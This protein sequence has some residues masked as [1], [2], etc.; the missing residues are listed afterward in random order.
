MYG[1]F[2]CTGS[3]CDTE[4]STYKSISDQNS[5]HGQLYPPIYE[6]IDQQQLP[7]HLP[8]NCGDGDERFPGNGLV[9]TNN[10]KQQKAVIVMNEA[11][12][13]CPPRVVSTVRNN[14]AAS[15]LPPSNGRGGGWGS[16]ADQKPTPHPL[17]S[18]SGT[19][20]ASPLSGRLSSH[21]SPRSSS[22]SSSVYYYSDTLRRP[23]GGGGDL[24]RQDTTDSGVSSS[25]SPTC[26]QNNNNSSG[27]LTTPRSLGR[28]PGVLS[29]PPPPASLLAANG[30]RAVK[31]QERLR[32]IQTQVTDG[33]HALGNIQH[34]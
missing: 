21:R 31:A 1:I 15:P 13:G 27:E 5:T 2:L 12:G 3:D 16:S 6:E 10:N 24:T 32:P 22:S 8:A 34:V 4:S 18:H 30:V 7:P 25:N 14:L 19:S 33:R 17:R 9:P 28:G 23:H 11:K 26:L 20:R 29:S